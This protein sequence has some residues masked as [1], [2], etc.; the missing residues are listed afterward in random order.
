[1]FNQPFTLE[2]PKDM[3]S[4]CKFLLI[5][6]SFLMLDDRLTLQ[7]AWKRVACRNFL[8]SGVTSVCRGIPPCQQ[9][10]GRPVQV[11]LRHWPPPQPLNLAASHPPWWP[12]TPQAWK[13]TIRWKLAAWPLSK[14][15]WPSTVRIENSSAVKPVWNDPSGKTTLSRP[16]KVPC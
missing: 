2:S 4:I 9:T 11:L 8:R 10:L 12:T 14:P 16:W 13:K 1:M 7:M 3:T 6:T 5:E 15:R